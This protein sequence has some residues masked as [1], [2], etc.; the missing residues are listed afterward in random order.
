[1]AP[2]EAIDGDDATLAAATAW[3]KTQPVCALGSH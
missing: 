1:V 3:L 2:D